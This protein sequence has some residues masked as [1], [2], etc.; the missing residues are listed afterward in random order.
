MAT[1]GGGLV[2]DDNTSPHLSPP[3]DRLPDTTTSLL[4]RV[5]SGDGAARDRLLERYYTPLKRW[6][7]GRLPARARDLL[8][9]D[10]IVQNSLLRAL[11]HLKGFEP[12]RQGAFLA[13]LRRIALNQIRDEIRRVRRRPGRDDL[14]DDQRD[15]GPSPIERLL[16]KEKLQRYEAALAALP[17]DQQ[18]AI[19][20]SVEMGFNPQQIA[21][22]LGNA[23]PNAA[24]MYVAR[25][26]VRLA[27]AMH[28]R[29]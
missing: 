19:I 25:A 7:H 5:R 9:T 2:A 24:R 23:S 15:E 26:L 10:D 20:M 28:A 8:D 4:K 21:E 6:A 12:R 3:S 18:E 13:Y 27:E 14:P 22:A 1:R 29:G 16:G 17:E 11:D